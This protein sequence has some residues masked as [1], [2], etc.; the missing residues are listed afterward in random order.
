MTTRSRWLLAVLLAL[1]LGGPPAALAQG[2]AGHAVP[3]P[4][5]AG[6][7]PA[8]PA[9]EQPGQVPEGYAEVQL[10]P[11]RQQLIGLKVARAERATLSGTV[12]ATAL[13]QADETREAHVHPK[14]MGWVQEVYVGAV[15]Q[16]VKKGE[17]LYTLYS[18]ELYAT[19]AEYL[20]ARATSR[21]LAVAARERLR[22]WD[23]PEDEVRRIER[24]GPQRTVTFRAPRA[25][26]VIEK[27]ILA[28]HYVGP[29]VLLYRIADL[30]QVWVVAQV[31]EYEV[32]R[33]DATGQA[34]VSVQGVPGSRT[35]RVDHVY[36]T[37]DATSRTVKVRL[38]L[39][40]TDGRLRPGAFATVELPT[41]ATEALWVP[42]EAV[43]DTGARQVVYVALEGGRFRPTR[44]A[45]G[46]R[47]GGRTEVRAGLE[48]GQ[49]V[50]VSAQFL[51]D[52]ESRLR[53][54]EKPAAH[55]G[56]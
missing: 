56:H 2:H 38:V 48:A 43:V 40:N 34:Q 44:V 52:S 9:V 7:A 20:R 31:Y 27:G 55:G 35:A 32:E 46:R 12:R 25:G 47:A 18:Q 26:T 24:R 54:V 21:D 5:P 39:P 15:G 13:V 19:Q 37:V 42:D 14:L 50:V 41:R 45:V 23:V 29:E 8:A 11:E 53:G 49:Q 6:G 1:P 10:V 3:A 33:L 36:P 17:P 4:P 51:L 22:L 28:G 16:Q 30:S